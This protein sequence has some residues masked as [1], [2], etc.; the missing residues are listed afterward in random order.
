M[1]TRDELMKQKDKDILMNMRNGKK[2][3]ISKIAR[4]LKLPIST[5]ND[6]INHIEKNYLLKYS[7]LLN[8]N[9]LGYLG[10]AKIAVKTNNAGFLDFLKQ[11]ESVNA[12]YHVNEGYDYLIEVVFKDL[13]ELKQ[14]VY[15]IQDKVNECKI[16]HIINTVEK[17]RFM[18]E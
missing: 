9:K 12:I 10:H 18:T 2:L 13:I 5:V 16:F 6:R 17:E 1:R 14:F 3:N 11:H 7:A 4:Q 8:Y 15:S